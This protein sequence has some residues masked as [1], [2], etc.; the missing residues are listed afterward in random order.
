MNEVL[1]MS[2]KEFREMFEMLNAANRLAA[3]QLMESLLDDQEER[4]APKV[5]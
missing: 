3:L 2:E 4:P 1:K 5:S